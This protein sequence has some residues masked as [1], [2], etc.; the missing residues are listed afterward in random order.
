MAV[1]VYGAFSRPAPAAMGILELVI[2]GCMAL[3]V[4]VSWRGGLPDKRSLLM[5]AVIWVAAMIGWGRAIVDASPMI[6]ILRDL[7]P[8]LFWLLPC[9]MRSNL[10]SGP[11]NQGISNFTSL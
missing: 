8:F 9:L 7:L 3:A 11:I 6:L 2:V 1:L 10:G 5:A 4:G